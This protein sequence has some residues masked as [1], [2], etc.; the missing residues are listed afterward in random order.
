MIFIDAH[1]AIAYDFYCTLFWHVVE[2]AKPKVRVL[3]QGELTSFG[4]FLKKEAEADEED[5]EDEEDD[6]GDDYTR[7]LLCNISF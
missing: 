2:K 7:T 4:K 6:F 3:T 5:E 1:I